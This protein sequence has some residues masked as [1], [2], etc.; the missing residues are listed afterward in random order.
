[1]GDTLQQQ[2]KDALVKLQ[3][4]L[5]WY[6]KNR[7]SNTYVGQFLD[8]EGCKNEQAGI[9]GMSIW[10]VL[11]NDIRTDSDILIIRNQCKE[12]LKEIVNKAKAKLS[13]SANIQPT[14]DEY[15]IRYIVPKICYAF[16]ALNQLDDAKTEAGTLQKYISDA[17][18]DDGSWGFLIGSNEGSS[19]ITSLVLRSFKAEPS[20]IVNLKNGLD[21]IKTNFNNIGNLY[22][23]L[24]VLNTIQM[25]DKIETNRKVDVEKYIKIT[26]R[27]LYKEVYYNPTKFANP[28][29]IDYNDTG[30]RRTR[31]FRIPTDMILLESLTLISGSNLQYLHAHAGRRILKYLSDSLKKSSK[32]TKDT[33]GHRASVGFYFFVTSVLKLISDKR[34]SRLSNF[35]KDIHGWFDCSISFGM[36]FTYNLLIL[37]ITL[38]ILILASLYQV[39]VITQLFIGIFIKYLLDLFK[40]LYNLS[41]AWGEL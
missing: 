11:T 1:M 30:A 18:K 36:D 15:E 37:I 34:T 8:E 23:R 21:Y 7:H 26:I 29:N 24:F 10:L 28:I 32:F 41:K 14:S 16:E 27:D 40:S 5:K 19:V 13:R 3:D 4:C 17:Q 31:Y 9:Y 25:L 22:E 2:A 33:S 12:K 20:F 39:T 35:A 38:V 6:S